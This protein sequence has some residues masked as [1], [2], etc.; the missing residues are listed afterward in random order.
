MINL[1]TCPATED[2]SGEQGSG[3]RR[4]FA[5]CSICLTPFENTADVFPH[6]V[7]RPMCE[8]CAENV[9][10]A[11]RKAAWKVAARARLFRTL[12]AA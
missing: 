10:C 6:V 2:Y 12:Q 11:I 7:P 5:F 9:E 4:L 1:G 8:K 3:L